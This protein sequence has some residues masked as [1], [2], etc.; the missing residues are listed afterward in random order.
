[1]A[2]SKAAAWRVQ[3]KEKDLA[4]IIRQNMARS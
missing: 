4:V 2:N 1:M 3:A